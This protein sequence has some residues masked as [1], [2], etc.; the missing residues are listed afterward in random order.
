MRT[1]EV[2]RLAGC[3]VQQVRKLAERGVLPSVARTDSGY[4]EYGAVHLASLLAYRSLTSA[5]G[6]TEARLL[7]VESHRDEVAMLARLDAAHA[8]LHREREE[9]ALARAAIESIRDEPIGEVLPTDS[10]TIGQLAEALGVRPSTLRHWEDEGLLAPPRGPHRERVFTPADVRDAR[11]VH[12]M[13][14][15]GHRIAPLRD[16]LPSVRDEQARAV[17]TERDRSVIARSTALLEATVALRDI[18][19]G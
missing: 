2:A 6:P 14:R 11:L 16:L 17:L 19:R 8:G 3:S 4:R 15:A 5:V 9:L 12:Q 1:G 13:R 10:L 7:M 18:S